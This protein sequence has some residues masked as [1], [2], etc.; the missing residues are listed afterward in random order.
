M[1]IDKR[2]NNQL[3]KIKIT[4]HFM[5]NAEGSCLFE[6]GDTK[7]ICTASI[8]QTVPPF[9]RGQGT[10]WI[11]AEYGMLP[12]SCGQRIQREAAKGKQQGRTVEIQRLIGR[13]IRTIC[14]M[15]KLGERTIKIDCDVLQGDGGTRCAS[16]SGSY[17]A[18]M[19]ALTKL[20][21]QGLIECI[22]IQDSVAAVSVGIL[23]GKNILDLCYKEDSTAEVD[24]NIIMTGKGKFIEIQG[25]AEKDPFSEE[26]MQEMITLAKKGIK[27]IIK[28]QKQVI[29]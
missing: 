23:E 28:V 9:M 8:E 11:T 3:R 20:K 26:Q 2:K 21:K 13:S 16:I 6:I 4:P 5:P 24:M 10:G 17:V 12:C 25:T 27:E 19:L 18:L 14:D 15:S 29:G 22:P 1:R 7:V